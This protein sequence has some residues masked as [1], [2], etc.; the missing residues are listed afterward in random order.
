MTFLYDQ[1]GELVATT[2]FS[3]DCPSCG[4]GTVLFTGGEMVPHGCDYVPPSLMI[5]CRPPL[6]DPDGG[7]R[8][9]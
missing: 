1:A 8:G 2:E 6:Q 7:R 4:P 9:D 3:M 5:D